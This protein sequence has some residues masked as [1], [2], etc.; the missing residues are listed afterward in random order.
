MVSILIVHD[1]FYQSIYIYC[2]S[3]ALPMLRGSTW[4]PEHP[5]F[6]S[7]Q[8]WWIMLILRWDAMTVSPWYISQ[9]HMTSHL[10]WLIAPC[11]ITC[12]SGMR[13]VMGFMGC[14]FDT[15]YTRDAFKKETSWTICLTKSPPGLDGCWNF[16]C[17]KE[18]KKKAVFA[19]IGWDGM[20]V[21]LRVHD[22]Y[23]TLQILG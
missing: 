21:F 15:S 8:A 3:C 9:G 16:L 17:A 10:T 2:I 1:R 20:K 4:H 6:T 12:T 19:W 18:T 23:E 11:G 14:I 22:K 5:C 13:Q 7:K